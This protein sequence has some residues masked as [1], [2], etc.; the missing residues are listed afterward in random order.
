MNIQRKIEPYFAKIKRT[1]TKFSLKFLNSNSFL[2]WPSAA[3]DSCLQFQYIDMKIVNKNGPLLLGFRW[4]P[5][6]GSCIVIRAR[7]IV[8]V[9]RSFVLSTNAEN[10]C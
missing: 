6:C 4:S 2:S 3:K 5:K 10:L 1:V 9:V 7:V 8:C